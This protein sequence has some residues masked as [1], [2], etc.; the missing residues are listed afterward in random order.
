[1]TNKVWS[2]QYVIWLAPLVVLARPRIWSYALWQLA[3]AGYFFAIWAYLLTES[4]GPGGIGSGLYFTAL[5]ARFAAVGLLC[6]LV[7]KDIL[8]PDTDVVRANGIDDPA[9]GVLDGAED[10][11]VLRLARPQ[12]VS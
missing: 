7:V 12:I 4:G 5:L 8:R 10:Q 3:E 9:G 6:I 11:L 1:M 2:P